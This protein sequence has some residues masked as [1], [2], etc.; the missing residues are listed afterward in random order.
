MTPR[1]PALALL[2]ALLSPGP[3]W[4]AEWRFCVGVAPSAHETI[5]TDIFASPAE[6]A[7]IEHRLEAYFRTR[8]GMSPTFQCPRGAPE[9][10][11]AINAQTA[12]LQ[13]NRKLGYAVNGLPA[14]EIASLV[15]DEAF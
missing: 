4:S 8:K 11:A 2:L 12:A 6:S 3:G 9:R 7:R 10:F 14:A 1:A 15:G 13:F 5:I